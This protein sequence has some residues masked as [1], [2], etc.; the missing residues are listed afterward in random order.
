MS[1]QCVEDLS[2]YG[3]F[4]CTKDGINGTAFGQMGIAV[5]L[6]GGVVGEPDGDKV[7]QRGVGLPVAASA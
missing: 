5:G 7:V 2:G 1:G 3:A 6:G 4:E